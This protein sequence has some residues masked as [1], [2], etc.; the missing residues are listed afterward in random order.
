MLVQLEL[1]LAVKLDIQT[2]VIDIDQKK[3]AKDNHIAQDKY[4]DAHF[5]GNMVFT[6][7]HDSLNPVRLPANGLQ[8]HHEHHQEPGE[9]NHQG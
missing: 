3:Q 7:R 4:P 2:P 5:T 8:Q 6:P 1:G 9:E